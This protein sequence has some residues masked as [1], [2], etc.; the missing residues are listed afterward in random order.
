MSIVSPL[1]GGCQGVVVFYFGHFG[2]G[3]VLVYIMCMGTYYISGLRGEGIGAG[4]GKGRAFWSCLSV[5][6]GPVVL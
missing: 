2:Q 1:L 4:D 6:S 5:C 3:G